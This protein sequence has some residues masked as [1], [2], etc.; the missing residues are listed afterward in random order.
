MRLTDLLDAGT[1]TLCG[2]HD[3]SGVI[4]T[5]LTSDSRTVR[6]GFLFAALP[7][8]RLDGSGFIAD[9]LTRGAAAVLVSS[10][11][12]PT[13]SLL[14][15]AGGA[16]PLIVDDNPRRCLALMTARFF[17]RQPKWIAAV[18][19][20]NGKTSVVWF[21]RQIW[22]ALG[23]PAAALG[24]LGLVTP[25]AT[26]PGSLTTPDPVALHRTLARLAAEGIEYTALE[27]SSHGLDQHRLDGVRIAA[28]AFTTL[29][30]DHLD[31]HASEEAYFAAKLRLF[32]DCVT[33]GGTAVINAD[34]PQAAR[35]IAAASP[36]LKVVSYGRAGDAL[37]LMS[38]TDSESGQ[39]LTVVINGTAAHPLKLPLIGD[40]QAMNALC[41]AGLACAT[42]AVPEA[43]L[44]ALETL[45]P[46]PGRLERVGAARGGAAPVFVDYAHTPDALAA[47][48]SA[49]RPHA[50]GRLMVVFGCGGD[51]DA[52]KRPQMG[53]VAARLA[54][55][56]F[57]TDD[58]PRSER[59]DAIRAQILAACPDANEIADRAEAICVAVRALTAGDV[60]LIAGKGHETGQ[61][62]GG[63]VLPF[64]DRVVAA[65]ALSEVAA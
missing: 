28:A 40:F 32:S 27:A 31:Y 24:T 8:A 64:D 45:R 52:G 21:L 54:D 3:A 50:R 15:P 44:A 59:P 55:L 46:V 48:L 22:Q 37:R 4:I 29:G 61:I 18:T 63:R 34:A 41:A 49:L 65:T 36:R 35:V 39:A 10:E 25:T 26:K 30:R 51:R 43:A 20:T 5:G 16:V 53:A 13:A 12:A 1:G 33:P 11:G 6:P 17:G 7:G 2:D 56:V 58:N 42:G 62:V 14:G 23:H 57:V 19:G 38:R 9:A 60:L 47:A